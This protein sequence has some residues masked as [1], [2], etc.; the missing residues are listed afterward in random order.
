MAEEN[1]TLSD[2]TSA[3]KQISANAAARKV[4]RDA[5]RAAATAERDA[6][7]AAATAERR[8]KMSSKPMS[9]GSSIQGLKGLRGGFGGKIV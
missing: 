5:E 6:E 9:K 2:V 8:K 3:L 4:K 1:K 7:R